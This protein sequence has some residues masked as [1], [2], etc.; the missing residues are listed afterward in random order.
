MFLNKKMSTFGYFSNSLGAMGDPSFALQYYNYMQGRW[1][2]G[3]P[4]TYGGDGY[5]PSSTDYTKYIF[6][7]DPVAGTGW[8]EVT[9]DGPESTP[10]TLDDRRGVMSAGPFNLNAG[11]AI[12]IDI[13]L[14]WA[15]DEQGDNITSVALLKAHAQM[16]Q[17]FYDHV[18]VGIDDHAALNNN[19]LIYPN[20]SNG[21]FTV[22]CESAIETIE[23]YDILGKKVFTDTPKAQTTQIDTHLP[24][25]LYIYRVTLA[26]QT[27]RI[28]KIVVQ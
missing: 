14:P 2:D 21:Q 12:T 11:D 23:L 10:N 9:P 3:L 24:N 7:G 22:T 4:F 25:G 16:I 28:G 17:N 15:R 6:S 20:P 27:L 26:D 8:T 18:I 19:L 5:D 1:S 13:A